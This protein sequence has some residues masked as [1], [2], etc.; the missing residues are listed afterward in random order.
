MR[1]LSPLELEGL[2]YPMNAT[3]VEMAGR[4]SVAAAVAFLEREKAF[5]IP[6]FART[7]T[8]YG[9]EQADVE[10]L[11]WLALRAKSMGAK[12]SGPVG[13]VDHRWWW[14]TV[15]RPNTVLT[16]VFGP[17]HICVGCH[18][19]LHA[20]RV[21]FCIKTGVGRVI[22]GERVL[23]GGRVKVNQAPEAVEAYSRVA[24][25]FGVE[26]LFPIYQVDD[27]DE[28]KKLVGTGW[29]EG[30]R[31]WSCVL[32]GN[33]LDE[34]GCASFSTTSLEAYLERYLVPVTMSI[35]ESISNGESPDHFSKVRK[36]LS[37]LGP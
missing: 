9:G 15:G 34:K 37:G 12:V 1:Y 6:T 2:A 5:L 4:D 27:E 33:Y 3:A 13:L 30:E 19:Y 17:W 8:E 23:H 16:R 21:A 20:L 31:Q 10:N 25:A 35:L 22:S 14:A 24:A 18:M 7:G 11:K 29:G 32:S 36:A 28:L 26:L